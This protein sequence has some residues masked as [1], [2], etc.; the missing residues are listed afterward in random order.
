MRAAITAMP[1][2]GVHAPGL[3]RARVAGELA[4]PAGPTAVILPGSGMEM[5][6]I[7]GELVP[8]YSEVTLQAINATNNPNF[9]DREMMFSVINYSARG[10][11]W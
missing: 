6:D 11:V 10:S 4:G 7:A 8:A 3:A 5:A 1:A 9:C 2:P